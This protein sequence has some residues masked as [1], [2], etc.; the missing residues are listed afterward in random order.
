MLNDTPNDSTTLQFACAGPSVVA[1]GM[2]FLCPEGCYQIKKKQLVE[3]RE[4]V[5]LYQ[6]FTESMFLIASFEVNIR[7]HERSFVRTFKNPNRAPVKLPPEGA[8]EL[9]LWDAMVQLGCFR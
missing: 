5:V 1:Q 7:H 6:I 9:N 8:L 4:P 3:G 2:F